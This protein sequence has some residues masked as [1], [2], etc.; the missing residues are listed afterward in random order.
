MPPAALLAAQPPLPRQPPPA[1][2]LPACTHPQTPAG[3]MQDR[4]ELSSQGAIRAAGGC[5]EQHRPEIKAPSP[6]HLRSVTHIE[7]DLRCAVVGGQAM[8]RAGSVQAGR[9]M[10]WGWQVNAPWG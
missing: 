3:Q 8:S 4:E 7:E 1:A 5:Q 9:V 2:P 10:G 6:C